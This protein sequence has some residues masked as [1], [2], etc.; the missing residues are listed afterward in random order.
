MSMT[1]LALSNAI[2]HSEITAAVRRGRQ[3]RAEAVRTFIDR[4]FRHHP[5]D[6]SAPRV[7]VVC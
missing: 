1:P 3:L 5:T 4:V 6:A 2:P 7:P